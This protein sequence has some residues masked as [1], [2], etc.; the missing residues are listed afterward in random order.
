MLQHL[1]IFCDRRARQALFGRRLCKRGRERA[2]RREVEDTVAPLQH[3]HGIEGVAL[4][5]LRELRFERR[6]TACRSKSTVTHGTACTPRDLTQ[7]GGI[8]L[9]ELIA[10]EFAIGRERHV[11]NIEI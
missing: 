3:L 8:E 11:V 7:L 5:R 1:D 10:V 2:E 9:A 6:T 4:E